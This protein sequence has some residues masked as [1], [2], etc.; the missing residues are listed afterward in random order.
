MSPLQ[1]VRLERSALACNK[2][3]LYLLKPFLKQQYKGR[4]ISN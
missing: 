1:E 4:L 3:K 2:M